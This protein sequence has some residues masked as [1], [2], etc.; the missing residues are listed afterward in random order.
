MGLS[1]FV[2][3]KMLVFESNKQKSKLNIISYKIFDFCLIYGVRKK[4]ANLVMSRNIF[5]CILMQLMH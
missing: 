1:D 3:S 2:A 5:A 4:S